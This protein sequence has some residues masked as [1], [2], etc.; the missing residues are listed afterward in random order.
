M[1]V[2]GTLYGTRHGAR[3]RILNGSTGHVAQDN[4]LV[5]RRGA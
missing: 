4:P 1:S 2:S 5:R 3:E